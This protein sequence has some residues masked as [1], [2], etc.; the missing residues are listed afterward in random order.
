MTATQSKEDGT[1]RLIDSIEKAEHVSL[2]AVRSFVETVDGVFPHLGGEDAPRRKIISS[3][4]KMTEDLVGAANRLAQNV[5]E[6]TQK[7]VNESEHKLTS[8]TK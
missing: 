3:A 2:E 8:S 4:F 5:L 6:A 7:T 1:A